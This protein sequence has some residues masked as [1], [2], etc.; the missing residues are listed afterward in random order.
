M[1][2]LEE[3]PEK[4]QNLLQKLQ[5]EKPNWDVTYT[6]IDQLEDEAQ[7]QEFF[8]QYVGLLKSSVEEDPEAAALKNIGYAIGSFDRETADRWMRAL[9]GISH[10][11]VGKDIGKF[12]KSD[13]EE[14]K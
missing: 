12:L 13:R 2:N 11:V 6:A 9:P 10:P 7:I 4:P 14:G 8:L 1:K 3:V 5:A